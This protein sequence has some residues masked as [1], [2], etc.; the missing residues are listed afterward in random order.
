MT[1]LTLSIDGSRTVDATSLADLNTALEALTQAH[2]ADTP[3]AVRSGSLRWRDGGVWITVTLTLPTT[4]DSVDADRQMLAQ[5]A[6]DTGL[7]EDVETAMEAI[8]VGA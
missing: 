7:T 4:A 1:D 6:A 8:E 2:E 5:V 3:V